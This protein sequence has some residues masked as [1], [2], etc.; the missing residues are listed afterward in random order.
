MRADDGKRSVWFWNN[1]WNPTVRR[2]ISPFLTEISTGVPA[3]SII[4]RA[5]I[6]YRRLLEPNADGS[7]SYNILSP[8][9]EPINITHQLLIN[10]L[11]FQKYSFFENYIIR[12][13]IDQDKESDVDGY[14][15]ILYIWDILCYYQSRW[16]KVDSSYPIL[17]I[18][19][20]CLMSKEPAQLLKQPDKNPTITYFEIISW[21]LS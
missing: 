11:L 18:I 1:G 8:N 4:C 20:D 13:S 21:E 9:N 3:S 10:M 12:V 15:N 7:D 17:A 14:K 2:Y 16:G 19:W 6:S 5:V